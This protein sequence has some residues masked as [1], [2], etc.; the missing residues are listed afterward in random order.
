M[1]SNTLDHLGK[2]LLRV[3][4]GGILIFH[5][6]DKLFSGISAIESMV[7]ARGLP[8]L[9]AW[10]VFIGELIA[11]ALVILGWYTRLG[12]LLITANMVTAITLAHT[13]DIFQINQ[14]GGW[15]LELQGL[16]LFGGLSIALLGAGRYSVAGPN[17]PWN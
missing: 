6:V 13:A 9:F 5:G 8:A 11:P 16:F 15:Q 1:A 12:G 2:L 4:V 7:M 10:A 14:M 17:S 3:T